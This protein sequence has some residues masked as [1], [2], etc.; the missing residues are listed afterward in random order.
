MMSETLMAKSHDDNDW[1]GDIQNDD[2]VFKFMTLTTPNSTAGDV[3]NW[4][5]PNPDTRPLM[6]ATS[7]GSQYSAARS[8]HPG[9]VN[10]VMCD[11]S[12]RFAKNSIALQTWQAMGTMDGGEVVSNDN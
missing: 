1:R 2:G 4:I 10:A 8:R 6:W 3:V 11:G 7:A 9:G 5:N 12:I